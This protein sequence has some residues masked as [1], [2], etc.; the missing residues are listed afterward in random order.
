MFS[1]IKSLPIY[2]V[3]VFA[4]LACQN[5]SKQASSSENDQDTTSM[6]EVLDE[7]KSDKKAVPQERL[8]YTVSLGV[9]PDMNYEGEG[10]LIGHVNEGKTGYKAGLLKGDV[11]LEMGGEKINDLVSYTKVLGGFKKGDS[12]KITVKREDQLLSL[13]VE[14]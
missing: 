1:T 9:M 13:L 6:K 7:M 10:M 8:T 11:V 14:F 4:V 5:S 2:F 12:T 3:L